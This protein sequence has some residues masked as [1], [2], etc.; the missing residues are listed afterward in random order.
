VSQT[1]LIVRLVELV[2]L[3]FLV[4]GIALLLER[5]AWADC[6]TGVG[7]LCRHGLPVPDLCFPG[8][9]LAIFDKKESN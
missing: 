4:G 7:V 2:V 8:L 5:R 3:Y 1:E 9:R 6:T